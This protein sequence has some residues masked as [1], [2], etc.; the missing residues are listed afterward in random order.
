MSEL[1]SYFPFRNRKYRSY[2]IVGASIAVTG[3]I[4]YRTYKMDTLGRTKRCF[5]RLRTALQ[6][7]IDALASGGELLS[8]IVRDLELYIQS[9]S[10]EIPSSLSQVAKLLQ[11]SAVTGVT[12][13]TVRAM[14]RGFTG[15]ENEDKEVNAATR[16]Q[17]LLVD[18]VLGALLS[19]RGH[20]LV[21]MAVSMAARNAVAAYVETTAQQKSQYPPVKDAT[22][23]IIE[24][25][26][27]N[28]GQHIA[29]A[30]M[31]TLAREGMQIYMDKSL[32]INFYEDLFSSMAKPDHVEAVKECV[33][34]FAR[35]AVGAYLQSQEQSIQPAPSDNNAA[36][37]L[38]I[39]GKHSPS[40]S[41]HDD[42]CMGIH[43]PH[44]LEERHMGSTHNNKK[45][46]VE[47]MQAV[48]KQWL[49]VS[50]DPHGR[51]VMVGMAGATAREI[52]A[53]VGETFKGHQAMF[54]VALLLGLLTS[55][56]LQYLLRVLFQ[57]II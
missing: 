11:S 32:D 22:D 27:T 36:E 48:G 47:W 29:I 8:S 33:G 30:A 43:T 9:D 18:S 21:S 17:P 56:L 24:F 5:E 4:I 42:S 49:K 13:S 26:S 20:S 1:H 40:T 50:R 14:Y 45:S 31:A 6:Q 10:D 23:K 12:S 41:S 25:L 3:G 15:V 46:N 51:E 19:D 55:L 7:Y 52:T 2:V 39:G 28:K 37:W 16:D 44:A 35:E 34:T 53:A 57:Q 38:S 54:V